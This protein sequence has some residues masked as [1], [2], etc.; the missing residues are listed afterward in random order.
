MNEVQGE[1]LLPRKTSSTTT[2]NGNQCKTANSEDE[3]SCGDILSQGNM[4][5]LTP[6]IGTHNAKEWAT[7]S[8]YNPTCKIETI[9]GVSLFCPPSDAEITIL[10]LL[11]IAGQSTLILPNI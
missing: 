2:Y 11:G 7:Q 1:N 5:F 6:K 3:R 8:P 9:H 4:M 10:S